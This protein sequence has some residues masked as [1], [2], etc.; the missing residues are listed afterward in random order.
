MN[1]V[2]PLLIRADA[3][4]KIG[5]GHI[6]RCLALAQAWR[7]LGGEVYF[8]HAFAPSSLQ[9]RVRECGCSSELVSV[10][11]GSR[12]DAES[13]AA[14][15]K[16]CGA[17]W[18]VA[19]GY[20]FDA[21]WQAAVRASGLR[22]LLIDDLGQALHYHADIVLNQNVGAHPALYS[23]RDSHT[24]LL[25]G[26]AFA[27]LRREFVELPTRAPG[28]AGN[29]T[30]VL[31]T[32]GGSDPE[33]ATGA[34]LSALEPLPGLSVTVVAGAANPR[35]E[36]L[37]ARIARAGSDWRLIT[38]TR[39]MPELMAWADAA[40]S[41]AGSTV[42]EL[43]RSGLPAALI[44]T[45]E[46]QTGIISSL[47]G[48]GAILPLGRHP[49]VEV[50]A[51]GAALGAW[52]GDA[53]VREQMAR[54]LGAFV[55]GRGAARVRAALHP[56]LRITFLSDA[57][58]WAVPSVG[59]MAAQ[60]RSEGHEVM[61]LT[62]PDDLNTGDIAF[63]LSLGKIVRPAL[64]RRHAHN[65]VVHASALPQG[66]G[67]S[68]LTWQVLEGKSEIPVTLLEAAPGLD[69][70]PVHASRLLRFSGHELI[71]ELRAGLEQA[72]AE[73]CMDFVHD[74]PFRAGDA[75]PQEGASSYYPRR[76]PEDSRLDPELG[77]AAQ[78]NLLRV[79]DP[80]RYPAYFEH[81]GR[82]YEVRISPVPPA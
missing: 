11:P 53:Q 57:D 12:N 9:E 65:L 7:D 43:A 80:V 48:A 32:L 10:E 25:L 16:A 45:A 56:R 31:V 70:G 72:T 42:W 52:L 40:I 69:E 39:E 6:M 44:V 54:R 64:L 55:D 37:R 20:D 35:I 78:F 8:L 67:W 66:R 59:A 18:V 62:R 34:V 2:A 76:R 75:R 27:L 14:A 50:G 36:A 4:V 41:A 19:D 77:L 46:N 49:G 79:C 15:A 17:V 24:R 61:H 13:T 29:P 73:L 63:F 23:R 28:V 33:D 74:Y 81:Q 3:S 71:D 47:A 82:R 1:S 51:M 58:S 30:R 22:L 68:P 60:L 5:T 21:A 38:D 26:P